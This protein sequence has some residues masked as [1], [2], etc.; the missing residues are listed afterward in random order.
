[1]QKGLAPT[2]DSLTLPKNDQER[3]ELL[4]RLQHFDGSF[5]LDDVLLR[6]LDLPSDEAARKSLSAM[7]LSQMQMAS[8][9][10]VAAILAIQFMCTALVDL[11]DSWLSLAEKTIDWL[12]DAGEDELARR[13]LAS[14]NESPDS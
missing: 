9:A 7:N 3:L 6:L 4:A 8:D 10:I 14:F 5:K 2:E 13:L 12:A 11:K 1:V